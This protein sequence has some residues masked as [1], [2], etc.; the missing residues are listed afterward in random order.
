MSAET[1]ASE[2]PFTY[3]VTKAG[4]MRLMIE[5]P[6]DD[7]FVVEYARPLTQQEFWELCSLNRELVLER[8][9]DG[10]V[11]FMSPVGFNSGNIEITVG[12]Y[13]KIW[14]VEQGLGDVASSSTGFILPNGS[15]RSPDAAWISDERMAAVPEEEL[16]QFPHLVPDFVVE[17]RSK[18]DNLLKLQKKMQEQWMPSGVRLSWLIDP[19]EEKVYVYR[20]NGSISVIESFADKL[21][22]EEV[23]PG[24]EFD[25]ARLKK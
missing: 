23:L 7:P 16:E 17:I 12:A 19:K 4:K 14:S 6:T 9:E 24:F 8:E 25:L 10:K 5:L 21:S 22:G 3:R 11:S 15:T 2:T 1:K 13:L 18:S 20:E